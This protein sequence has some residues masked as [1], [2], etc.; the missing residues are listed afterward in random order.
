MSVRGTG[1]VHAERSV[2]VLFWSHLDS[3]VHRTLCDVLSIS[4]TY[5]SFEVFGVAT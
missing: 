2:P 1:G 3:V 4:A 5:D